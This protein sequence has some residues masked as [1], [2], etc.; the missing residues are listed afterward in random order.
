MNAVRT[1]DSSFIP[2]QPFAHQSRWGYHPV[3][4]VSFKMLKEFQ[5]LIWEELRM[6]YVW[7]RWDRKEEQNQGKEPEK[8]RFFFSF[9]RHAYG[10]F[11]FFDKDKETGQREKKKFNLKAIDFVVSPD[12][13]HILEMYNRARVPVEN[14]EDVEHFTEEEWQAFARTVEFFAD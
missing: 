7:E 5:R 11:F 6:A 12:A 14:P 9:K 3:D 10:N 4:A 13:R 1:E 8:P 2:P